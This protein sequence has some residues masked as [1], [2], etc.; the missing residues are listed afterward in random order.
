[1][2]EH[3][4]GGCR[5]TPLA[6]YLKALGILRLVA[7]QKDPAARGW[8]QAD[9]FR[10]RTA[11][12]RDG[13]MRFFLEEY[14]PTPIIAPWNGGSGFYFRERKSKEKDPETGKRSKL[15]VRD[16]PTTATRTLSAVEQSACK[17]LSAYRNAI[18]KAR[19]LIGELELTAAPSD[20]QK[21]HLFGLL[22][23]HADEEVLA[24]LD[25]AAALLPD[26]AKYPPLLGTGGNDGNLDFSTN[27]HQRITQLFDLESGQPTAASAER[28]ESALLGN[29]P[30]SVDD[31]AIGQ[32]APAAGG[33]LNNSTGFWGGARVNAWDFVLNLEGALAFAGGVSRRLDGAGGAFLSYPFTFRAAASGFGSASL[34][35]LAD[36]R[37]ELWIPIWRRPTTFGE[38]RSLFREGRLSLGARPVRD[39]LDAARAVGSLASDRRIAAFE[40]YGFLKRFGKSYLATPLGR[41]LVEHNPAGELLTDLDRGRWLENLRNKASSDDGS[42]ALRSAVRS[43]EDAIFAILDRKPTPREIQDLL[44]SLGRAARCIA[45]RPKLHESLHPP[46]RLS[47][48]WIAAADDG[49]S[50]F[51]LA[52]A[53]AGLRRAHAEAQGGMEAEASAAPEPGD[54]AAADD[55]AG[56]GNSDGAA[57][58]GGDASGTAA[59]HIV[60]LAMCAHLGPLDPD[61]LLR[62]PRWAGNAKRAGDGRA[63]AVWGE[64]ALLDNLC[65]VAQRRLIEQR[66]RGL[67]EVPFDGA[68]GATSGDIRAFLDGAVDDAHIADLLL[69]LAWVRP[70]H[71]A[72]KGESAPPPFA[73]AALKPLFTPRRLLERLNEERGRADREHRLPYDIPDLPLPPT[74]PS[75]LAAGRVAEAVRLGQQRAQASGLPAP[76][77]DPRSR[78]DGRPSDVAFGRRLLAALVIPV[79]DRVVEACLKRAYPPDGR[80]PVDSFMEESHDAA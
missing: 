13:L 73:Y 7:E 6:S 35:E 57:Q 52:L 31:A 54:D 19:A 65:A 36:T 40:R 22:R 9:R 17:R 10:L 70:R 12:D 79:A 21:E 4:L 23:S 41:R 34:D 66:R 78:T 55:G 15:G 51:R 28:L 33:G 44:I 46:P 72:S 63:L 29:L 48:D 56:A 1:M 75:L 61:S 43:L 49:S 38:L 53:L 42:A 59:R 58:P 32:F 76:F 62:R 60:D 50:E 27:F 39:G 30:A 77:L 69:G 71:P 14:R 3:I 47:A 24:W 26:G 45:Q 74:L 20:E 11:L 64:G 68:Y 5:P 67:A 16:E 80:E 2:P 25:T 18:S 8:W 37:G